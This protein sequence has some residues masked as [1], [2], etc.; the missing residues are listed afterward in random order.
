V[1]R[2]DCE[3]PPD[4]V[5]GQGI[6]PDLQKH[7]SPL[8]NARDPKR[9]KH[10]INC[11][12]WPMADNYCKKRKQRL[13][14]EAEW[15]FAARGQT[16]R[17]YPWGD[18]APSARTLNACGKECVA[19]GAANGL[20]HEPMYQEDDHYPA[21]A[22]VGSFPAGASA[23][24]VLDLAGNVWEWTADWYAP[25]GPEAQVDPK[26]PK[27]GDKRVARGGDYFGYQADWARPAYRFRADPETTYNHAI[28]F[29][30]AADARAGHD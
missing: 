28:G 11:V 29:R 30:C 7:L 2:G 25:Y 12:A 16:Q 27:A 23:D 6:T 10:P 8:C 20:P 18:E 15:E 1:S 9:A 4:K 26:G 17:M 13:P 14:T 24:G 19:W 21:T 3:K 22:P 5:S